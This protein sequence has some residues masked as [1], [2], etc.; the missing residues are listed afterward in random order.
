[1]R[2]DSGPEGLGAVGGVVCL[3]GLGGLGAGVVC[4]A[5]TGGD[6]VGDRTEGIWLPTYLGLVVCSA[7]GCGVEIGAAATATELVLELVG[8]KVVVGIKFDS[9]EVEVAV[10]NK[11]VS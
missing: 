8:F 3:S 10:R 4:G 6:N 7:M 9:V 11:A 5:L 2:T 1:L